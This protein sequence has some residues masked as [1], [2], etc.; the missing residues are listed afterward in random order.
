MCCAKHM[1]I[2]RP[3]ADG[4]GLLPCRSRLTDC[5]VIADAQEGATPPGGPA[6]LAG[7]AYFQEAWKRNE[8]VALG[9]LLSTGQYSLAR[10]IIDS[11][12][13]RQDDLTGRLPYARDRSDPSSSSRR[14]APF[15]RCFGLRNWFI[16]HRGHRCTDPK[17]V[18]GRALLPP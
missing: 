7:D 14:P 9:G 16:Y 15:G 10:T 5:L 2:V 13:Q 17:T 6:I 3:R 1:I 8:D 11:T 4:S 18:V 12:W